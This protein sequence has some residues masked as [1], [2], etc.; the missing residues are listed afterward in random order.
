MKLTRQQMGASLMRNEDDL[1]ADIL[2][3]LAEMRPQVVQ[4]YPPG[5]FI[6]LIRES[7]RLGMRH[8]MTDVEH[9]RVFVDLRWQ[10]AAGWFREPEIA[11]VLLRAGLSP[12]QRFA[13]LTGPEF[14]AAWE[15]A[16][17]RDTPADWRGEFWEPAR[18]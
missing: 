3:Y 6:A 7:V 17:A 4:A 18:E 13:I 9:M 5:Y 8:N 2:E 10:I 12:E 16:E 1:V 15:R 14:D 11:E